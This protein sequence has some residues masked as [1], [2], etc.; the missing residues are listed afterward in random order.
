MARSPHL[1]LRLRLQLW[2]GGAHRSGRLPWLGTAIRVPEL[3]GVPWCVGWWASVAVGMVD[4]HR[5][6][7][8]REGLMFIVILLRVDEVHTG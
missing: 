1:P 3:V 5:Y 4:V 8:V 7:V 2:P 6:I